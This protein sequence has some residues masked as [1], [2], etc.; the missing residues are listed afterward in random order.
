MNPTT[1]FYILIAIIVINFIVDFVLDSLNAKNYGT[2]LPNELQDVYPEDEYE[3]SMAYKKANHG[4]GLVS[5]L[6]SLLLT[7]GFFFAGGF[8]LVNDFALGF[9]SNPIIVGLIFLE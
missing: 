9:S 2:T 8:K 4:F 1:V 5:S 6:F 7:L 3:K